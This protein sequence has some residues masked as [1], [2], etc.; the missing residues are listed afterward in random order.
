MPSVDVLFRSVARTAG[1]NALG[2]IMTGMGDDG[3]NG[4]LEMRNLGSR[5]I[6]QDEASCVVF[7]MPKEAIK[8]NAA[9]QIL[10]LSDL[11]R[12]IMAWH[13]TAEAGSHGTRA[14]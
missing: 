4:L 5:T 11:P 7:G 1:R 14:S 3:A 8:R 2:V 13:A 6:A 10:S 12:A 9:D